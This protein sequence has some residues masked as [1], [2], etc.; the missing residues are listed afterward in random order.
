MS[1][2]WGALQEDL[3][4]IERTAEQSQKLVVVLLSSRPLIIT[5]EIEKWDALVAAWLPGT[6]GQGVADGLFGQSPITGKLSFE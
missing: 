6:E 4:V 1:L 3:K 2:T 5:D